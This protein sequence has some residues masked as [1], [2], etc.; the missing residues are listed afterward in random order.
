MP[1]RIPLLLKLLSPCQDFTSVTVRCASLS[2]FF[3]A[4]IHRKHRGRRA[5]NS[6]IQT[7]AGWGQTMS[8]NLGHKF[9]VPKKS[10]EC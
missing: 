6:L 1:V 2:L 5:V 9:P 4:R 3:S 7:G 10:R 8:Q